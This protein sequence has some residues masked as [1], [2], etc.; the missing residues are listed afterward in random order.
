[1]AETHMEMEVAVSVSRPIEAVGM[2]EDTVST[3]FVPANEDA[4]ADE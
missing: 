3:E 4:K 2:A 1:M